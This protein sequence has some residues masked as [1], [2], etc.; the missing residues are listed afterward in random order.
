MGLGKFVGGWSGSKRIQPFHLKLG[1]PWHFIKGISVS[2]WMM[3][4][5][6]HVTCDNYFFAIYFVPNLH[7]YKEIWFNSVCLLVKTISTRF[8]QLI[9]VFVN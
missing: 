2:F 5:L 1:S 7:L 4:F 8:T 6:Y 3:D 9:G